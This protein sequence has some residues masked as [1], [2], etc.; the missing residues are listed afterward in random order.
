MRINEGDSV[1]LWTSNTI[2]WDYNAEVMIING[3]AY[4]GATVALALGAAALSF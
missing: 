2:G 3:A 4:L 1:T